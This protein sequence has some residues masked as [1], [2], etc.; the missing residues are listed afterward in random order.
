V[1]RVAAVTIVHLP[2]TVVGELYFGAQKS[3]Q[4]ATNLQKVDDLVA[5]SVMLP[6]DLDTA[7]IYGQIK[8]QL[9]SQG[10]PI[11]DN[12]IW[13]AAVARQHSLRLL[14]RDRHFQRIVPLDLEI[15]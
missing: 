14:A 6:C 3:L 4:P 5:R 1:Q 2:A 8:Q 9:S 7:R 10:T 13:I 12:D 15:L 11:P